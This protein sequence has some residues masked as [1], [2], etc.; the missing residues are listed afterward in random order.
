MNFLKNYIKKHFALSVTVFCI[1]LASA[2]AGIHFA[3]SANGELME[4]ISTYI[5]GI[6][7]DDIKFGEIFKN[8]IYTNF[9]YTLLICFSSAHICFFPLCLLLVGFKGFSAAFTASFIIR[10]F[11]FKGMAATLGSVVLPVFLSLPVL[12]LMYISGMHFAF[13]TFRLRKQISSDERWKMYALHVIKLMCL[14]LV[15]SIVTLLEA[16]LTPYFLSVLTK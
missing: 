2:L 13:E 10:I 14:F 11:S 16:F 15:L 12:F 8:G 9:K 7:T 6:L 3:F 1:Y 4:E 5:N